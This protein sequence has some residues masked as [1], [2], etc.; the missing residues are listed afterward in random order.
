[1]GTNPN[2]S[3]L[4]VPPPPI[5][6]NPEL[7]ALHN[8]LYQKFSLSLSVLSQNH[9]TTISKLRTIQSDLLAGEPAIKDEMARLEAVKD[10]CN[11]VVRKLNDVVG[12]MEVRVEEMK[13]KGEPGVDELVCS[14]DVVY[15]Q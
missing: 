13:R 3:H 8:S 12:Q 6:P 11:S 2:E 1:M 7:L 10:V 4:P 9:E 5:P 14:S 15:N